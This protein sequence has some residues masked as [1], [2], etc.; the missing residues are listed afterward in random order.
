MEVS[1]S[2][3]CP[4]QNVKVGWTTEFDATKSCWGWGTDHFTFDEF[5]QCNSFEIVVKIK[6]DE[7]DNIT[8]IREWEQFERGYI[9]WDCPEEKAFLEASNGGASDGM[10]QKVEFEV[11]QKDSADFG[12]GSP[13]KG[14]PYQV[15]HVVKCHDV[16]RC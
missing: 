15:C 2:I 1:W 14:G 10:Y 8:A 7:E 12:P 16:G 11:P 6:V 13:R 9:E 4:E 5:Q 3:Q